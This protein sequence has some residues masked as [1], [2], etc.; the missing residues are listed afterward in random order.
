MTDYERLLLEAIAEKLGLPLAAIRAEADRLEE[1][2]KAGLLAFYG[3]P[4]ETTT[5]R[6]TTFVDY[7]YLPVPTLAEVTVG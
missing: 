5:T 6:A 2:Y 7:H 3:M 4:P 1:E